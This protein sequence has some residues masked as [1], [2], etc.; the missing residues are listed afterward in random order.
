[1]KNRVRY[2]T[3]WMGPISLDWF[4]ERGLTKRVT[5][6]LDEDSSF[7]GKK[8]GDVIEY[9]EII[10]SYKGG[11]LD[12]WNPYSDS[13]YPDEMGVPPMRA[14]DWDRFGNWLYEFETDKV[15]TLKEIVV[16]YEK[17]NPSIRWWKEKDEKDERT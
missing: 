6:V 11:R 7:F 3:N 12:F 14:E 13:H 8:K 17:T 15:L 2:S 9:D 4:R 1:M 16:E 5:K 10:E